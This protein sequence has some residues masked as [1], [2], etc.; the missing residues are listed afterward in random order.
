MCAIER[1]N[2]VAVADRVAWATSEQILRPFS[3]GFATLLR[4]SPER[5]NKRDRSSTEFRGL[6]D[7]NKQKGVAAYMN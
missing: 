1:V 3:I 6:S 2:C 4:S 5:R 7:N